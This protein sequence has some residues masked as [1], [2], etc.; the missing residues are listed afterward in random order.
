[1]EEN[2]DSVP[3]SLID[4]ANISSLFKLLNNDRDDLLRQLRH[5]VLR[6]KEIVDEK[7]VCS[8]LIIISLESKNTNNT[9]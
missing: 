7:S 3:D 8:C 1:M 5:R 4:S 9:T 2:T 6:L